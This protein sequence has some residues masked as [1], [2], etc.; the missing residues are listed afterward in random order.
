M[1]LGRSVPGVH[2]S[3]A[4]YQEMATTNEMGNFELPAHAAEGQMVK[5]HAEKGNLA[6][7]LSAPAGATAELVLRKLR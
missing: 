7:D 5:V 3:I 6:A 1:N 2:V 4:G